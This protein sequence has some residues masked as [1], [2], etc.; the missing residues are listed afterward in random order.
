MYSTVKAGLA[1]CFAVCLVFSVSALAADDTSLNPGSNQPVLGR[2][3]VGEPGA[4]ID[5]TPTLDITMEHS[6][7]FHSMSITADDNY[8]YMINGGNSSYG[9]VLTYDLDGN[10]VDSVAASL[11]GRAIFYNPNDGTV[12][13]KVYGLD[14]YWVDPSTGAN[15]LVY[16]GIF[17]EYQAHVGFDPSTGYMYE[18]DYGTVYVVDIAN[19]NTINTMSGFTYGSGSGYGYAVC[20]DG[21]HLFTW[22][23]TQTHAYDMD[24]NY[25]ES[26]TLDYGSYG[27]SISW[28]NNRMFASDDANSGTG[29]W[30]GYTFEDVSMTCT[31]L[32][33]VFCRGKNFYFKLAVTNA[34]GGNVT[35]TLTFC[36]YAGYDCDPGN[37]LVGIPR[38]KTYVP[39]TTEEYYFF[40]V[41]NA[42]SPGQ[43]SASVGGTL[44][45]VDLFCC[46]NTDI[47]QCGPFRTGGSTE[48]AL[49]QV[50]RPDAALPTTTALHQNYP[51]PFNAE[52]NVS[53]SLAEAGNV[54]LKVYDLSGRLVTT[55]VDGQMDAGE[56]VVSWDA[57]NVSSGVYFLMLATADFSATKTMNLL[58]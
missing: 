21:Q 1:I 44:G 26:F 19:G 25:Q 7:R 20:T 18:H 33:P 2:A 39:G 52:T 49:E 31:C 8:Y 15:G 54:S 58:K 4:G 3:V 35:G 43:Y 16:S 40:K 9:R 22:D 41:P 38:S 12:Y 24:G 36:G 37:V 34:T 29:Y 28:A 17:H 42:A 57:S 23:E 50:D 14:L 32:S 51:N 30:Y 6:H 53:F 56:H 55:L 46:M 10:F 45:G 47:I 13:V 27:W 5:L 48:W 11:D